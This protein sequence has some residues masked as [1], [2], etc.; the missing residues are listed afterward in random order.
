LEAARTERENSS[1]ISIEIPF[2]RGTRSYDILEAYK[3]TPEFKADL[4]ICEY[5]GAVGATVEIMT[6]PIPDLC[7]ES[8]RLPVLNKDV[9][10]DNWD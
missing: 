10:H 5:M 8:G 6:R 3:A 1:D 7:S 4:A 2:R 9:L